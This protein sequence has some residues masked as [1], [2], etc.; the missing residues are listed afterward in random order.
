MTTVSFYFSAIQDCRYV[1]SSV[2]LTRHMGLLPNLWKEKGRTSM[3]SIRW[4]CLVVPITRALCVNED[5]QTTGKQYAVRNA[6][7]RKG[8]CVKG[9]LSSN[10]VSNTQFSNRYICISISTLDFNFP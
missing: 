4:T 6:H 3:A 5:G 8:V 7:N 10:S 2:R 9:E 1:E